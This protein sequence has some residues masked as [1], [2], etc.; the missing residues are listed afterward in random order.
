MRPQDHAEA[1][2]KRL[3]E[4][5]LGMGLKKVPE[6]STKSPD[7][8]PRRSEDARLAIEVK[9]LSVEESLALDDGWNAVKEFQP[10]S[11]LR[12]AW[13]LSVPRRTLDERY[14]AHLPTTVRTLT[15][16]DLGAGIAPTIVPNPERRPN[17]FGRPDF[18][19]LRREGERL[20]G[21]LEAAGIMSTRGNEYSLPEARELVAILHGGMAMAGDPVP[22]PGYQVLIESGFSPSGTGEPL[23]ARIAMFLASS[24][25]NNLR[26]TLAEGVEAGEAR[27]AFLVLDQTEPEV[28]DTSWLPESRLLRRP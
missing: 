28:F 27:H 20:L 9:L 13:F 1:L 21:A 19:R 16:E 12:F 25:S 22:G 15:I 24:K 4:A 26:A 11:L 3:A 10:C 18:R 6:R 23:I 5:V 17:E 14:P 7:F 2:A 8:R